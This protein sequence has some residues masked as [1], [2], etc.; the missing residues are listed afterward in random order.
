M[1]QFP[2][3]SEHFGQSS[4]AA[5]TGERV[6]G[7]QV[8]LF[9]SR[10]NPCRC[11]SAIIRRCKAVMLRLPSKEIETVPHNWEPAP[12]TIDGLKT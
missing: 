6:N 11:M 7:L 12:L 1:P 3:Q 5:S 2:Q 8:N 10:A 9:R 4:F